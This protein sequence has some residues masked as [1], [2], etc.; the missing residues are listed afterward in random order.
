LSESARPRSAFSALIK[1]NAAGQHYYCMALQPPR[2]SHHLP[3]P[4]HLAAQTILLR[5]AAGATWPNRLG[6]VPVLIAA[7]QVRNPPG[8]PCL[9]GERPQPR[10]TLSQTASIVSLDI[11]VL[12]PLPGP[13]VAAQYLQ[14]QRFSG[15]GRAH[16]AAA[17]CGLLPAPGLASDASSRTRLQTCQWQCH[18]LGLFRLL[19][20]E[21]GL[22]SGAVSERLIHDVTGSYA[23]C[24]IPHGLFRRLPHNES[25]GCRNARSW[26]LPRS[27]VLQ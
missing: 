17:S 26:S 9:P 25:M 24:R 27:H 21:S 16:S 20:Q 18:A 10:R 3:M 13:L 1:Q 12:H 22:D 4:H 7:L 11:L 2:N 6:T 8:T 23:T 14:L 15:L 5:P 19:I